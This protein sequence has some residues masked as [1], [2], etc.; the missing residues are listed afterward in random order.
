MRLRTKAIALKR[1]L[2]GCANFIPDGGSLFWRK[3]SAQHC[4]NNQVARGLSFLR[5]RKAG[6]FVHPHSFRALLVPGTMTEAG[7]ANNPVGGGAA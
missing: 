4:A 7:G 3:E 1:S 5:I 6:V 2:V